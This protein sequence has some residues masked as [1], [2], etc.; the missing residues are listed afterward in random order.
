MGRKTRVKGICIYYIY[1]HAVQSAVVCVCEKERERG[2]GSRE[3]NCAATAERW[4][5]AAVC[6]GVGGCGIDS[7]FYLALSPRDLT[8]PMAQASERAQQLQIAGF[9]RSACAFFA[10]VSAAAASCS[11]FLSR[12]AYY[13]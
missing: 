7:R 5:R 3:G 2:R 8:N 13:T 10:F 9:S 1:I 12:T 6:E 11:L 4:R